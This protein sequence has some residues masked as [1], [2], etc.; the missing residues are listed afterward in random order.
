MEDDNQ[1]QILA[2]LNRKMKDVEAKVL[3]SP[4]FKQLKARSA[5]LLWEHGSGEICQCPEWNQKYPQ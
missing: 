5:H 4:E 2:L 1:K 3:E